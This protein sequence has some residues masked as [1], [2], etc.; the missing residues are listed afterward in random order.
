[1]RRERQSS[2]DEQAI[3]L[4]PMLDVVF[5]MLIFFIVTATFI[6]LPGVDV[7]KAIA[8]NAA[9]LQPAMLVAIDSNSN[10]WI[11]R[12]QVNPNFLRSAI[13]ALLADN[14]AGTL[15]IQA[16][17]EAQIRQIALVADTARE[18]GVLT[19]QISTQEG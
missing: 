11:N 4:T 7:N 10:I 17:R 3:D 18:A 13:S 16:D 5:I 2:S 8:L 6:K 12:E 9:S 14:P 15:V 1:M 19:V